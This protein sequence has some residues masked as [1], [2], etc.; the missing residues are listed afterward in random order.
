MI[1]EG[2]VLGN[3][4]EIIEKVGNGGMATVYKA[5]DK[6]LK[7]NV[8]VKILRDEFTTDEEFIKRFEIEAQSAARL[9]H[10]NIV[11]IFDV[12][13]EENLY[14][15]VMELIQG[16]TLKE[17]IIEERGPLPWKWS[18]N[19][20]IQIASALEM[21]H[22]NN[23]IH[24]DIKPHNIIITEDGI[25]KVTDFGIA[26]AVSN[27]TITAFGTT[28]GSVH[29]FSPEHARGG[30]T[31]AKSDLYSLGVVMYEMVT[32][33]VPFDA[34]TPV[35]VALKH[36]QEDPEEP[37]EL[38]P[39][40]PGAVNKIIMKALKKD[41]TLRY[42]TA[43]EMLSDL[44]RALKN[45]DGEF[46][47]DREYDE[48]AKTQKI[49][50]DLYGNI[51][52]DSKAKNKK[53]KKEGRFKKFIK[54]HK[55]L[56]IVIGLVLLFAL[57]L[58]GT[59]AFLNLTNP[60]EVELPNLV[61]MSKEEAQKEAENLKLKIEIKEEEFNKEVPEGFIISQD[62]KYIEKYNV[63]EGSTITVVVSKGQEKTKVPNVKGKSQ[64]EALQLLEAA[65]LKAEIIEETSKTV[66]EGYVISQETEPDEEVFAGDT[67]KIHISKGTG[68]K[69]VNVVS[70]IGQSEANAKT[71]L[72]GLGLKVNVA[73]EED[74]SK[75]DGIVLK[76]SLEGGKTVNEG[77]TITITVNKIA[78]MK[79]VS[80]T[81]NV[82]SLLGGNIYEETSNTT[83]S[84]GDKKVKKVNLKV[85]V[86]NDT[87]YSGKVSASETSIKA[88]TKGTGTKEIK[89]YIDDV[90]KN[91]GQIKYG[92]MATYTAE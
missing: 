38:N 18:V 72:T 78:E 62:P 41:T 81:V 61:G 46:V 40:L 51:E 83:N 29:Y 1:L 69:Q 39:N 88:T 55:A 14:Y 44:R 35:S 89:V 27:S 20:A 37:I 67:V 26:K 63:K 32:G 30:F 23:I 11:S 34:D 13:V 21:A 56:S 3:R 5:E 8:A 9:V 75:A 2:K 80:V 24:R 60:P 91:Q 86:G 68:I 84:S 87:I 77:T 85:V 66:K 31:D 58:G 36:M 4:Y 82:K 45:P 70:V 12:G 54:E 10:P 22:K 50:T 73:Y 59:L 49:N 28:I 19:V 64:E 6:V 7:R 74:T 42:Q 33:K 90:L 52:E 57:S 76:Q 43:S 71:T 47:D 25:A 16:K 92:E 17:I 15:I 53:G 48:T 79:E 65:N